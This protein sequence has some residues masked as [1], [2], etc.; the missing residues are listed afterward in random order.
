MNKNKN[1]KELAQ[2]PNDLSGKV[3]V[4]RK[5]FQSEVAHEIVNS[6]VSFVNYLR[7]QYI[8]TDEIPQDAMKSYAVDYLEAQVLNGGFAQFAYN[9]RM[10]SATI[11]LILSGLQ[12]MSAAAHLEL[13]ELFIAEFNKLPDQRRR[14]Y[15]END[16]FGE[17]ATRD[18]IQ[19]AGL[20]DKFF[21][22][23][24]VSDLSTI[25]AQWLRGLSHLRVLSANE[26][27]AEAARRS[28]LISDFEE[29]KQR[30]L[31]AEPRYKK[32]IRRVCD[33]MEL[34]FERVTSMDHDFEIKGEKRTA[35][36]FWA[37]HQLLRFVEWQGSLS[38][39][40][41]ETNELLHTIQ[42]EE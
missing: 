24:K 14:E 27:Y 1:L 16:L 33:E 18:Q 10:S 4:S 30:A 32:L 21:A 38:V 6:N 31:D 23:N 11:E 15:F 8:Y 25:N 20:D 3:I 42:L 17:N 2:D 13:L 7:E 28:A 19:A 22:L 26:M 39:Y 40:V 37:S 36:I 29:R 9:S 34:D 12:E 35:W 41:Y 5:S